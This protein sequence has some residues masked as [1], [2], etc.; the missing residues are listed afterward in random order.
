VSTQID[1]DF[2]FSDYISPA[3]GL[4][5]LSEPFTHDEIDKVVSEMPGDK[6]PG[7]DGF[8]GLF[9]KVCWPIIKFDFY[10]LCHEFW[11]GSVN[12]QSIN[13]AF[14]TLIPKIHS[15]EGPNDYRPILLNSCLKLLTKLLASRLQKKILELVH[16]NQYGF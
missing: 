14:I 12:L 1:Q 15:P 5:S 6:A 13:D 11:E 4:E 9:L 16:Q 7:P 8:S 10:R 2:N 3:Q